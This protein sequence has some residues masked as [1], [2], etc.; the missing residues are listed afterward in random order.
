MESYKQ[1]KIDRVYHL[2]QSLS[3]HEMTRITEYARIFDDKAN[4]FHMQMFRFLREEEDYNHQRLKDAFP[5]KQVSRI[6]NYLHKF[7]YRALAVAGLHP[8]SD[9]SFLLSEISIAFRKKSP[10][11]AKVNIES[12]KAIARERELF[13]FSLD[14]I[15]KERKWLKSF[16]SEAISKDGMQQIWAEYDEINALIENHDHFIRLKEVYYYPS[17]NMALKTGKIDLDLLAGLSEEEGM[18]DE[19]FPKSNRARI[20]RYALW[21]WYHRGQGDYLSSL[22]AVAKE[23]ELFLSLEWLRIE[24]QERYFNVVHR[25]SLIAT[26]LGK[27]ETARKYLSI[28]HEAEDGTFNTALHLWNKSVI[29]SSM[30][31]LHFQDDSIRE[32]S[33]NYFEKWYDQIKPHLNKQEII[34]LLWNYLCDAMELRRYKK[35]KRIAYDLIGMRAADVREEMQIVGR[36]MHLVILFEEKDFIGLESYG[37]NYQLFIKKFRSDQDVSFFI[38]RF[39]RYSPRYID[40]GKLQANMEKLASIIESKMEEPEAQFLMHFFNFNK[41]LGEKLKGGI[42]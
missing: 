16:K 28:L 18:K 12:A 9:L 31:G 14:L 27:K 4:Q 3:E 10:F 11:Q 23:V 22:G 40:V 33:M 1:E 39:L 21:A 17:R 29:A 26:H 34:D 37:R 24:E 15:R 20:E 8:H 42:N 2:I 36:I 19:N 30:F 6:K 25:A 32:F 7:I 5:G 35:G 38:I 41:W 13:H